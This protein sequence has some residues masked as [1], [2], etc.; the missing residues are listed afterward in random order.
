MR[1]FTVLLA[2]LA[3]G[4]GSGRPPPPRLQ[5][6]AA[7]ALTPALVAY[8]RGF[9]GAAVHSAGVGALAD[10]IRRGPRPDLVAGP[11]RALPALYSAGLV[12][13]P[14]DF[15][16]ND[17]VLVVPVRDPRVGGLTQLS[18]SGVRIALGRA[19]SPVGMSTRM[20]LDRLGAAQRSAILGNVRDRA[21]DSAVLARLVAERRTDAAFVYRTAATRWRG[22]LLAIDLSDRLAPRVRFGIAVV[23]G[24]A[25][26]RAARAF[27]AGL[28]K[29]RGRRALNAAGFVTAPF[30]PR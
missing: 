23:S 20:V 6:A 24:A 30:R 19:G 4:C 27:V 17:L 8:A 11:S 26:P 25:H 14:L 29:A 12:E 13:K 2:L 21:G 15:A 18:G 28:D 5:V 16:Q 1:R 10:R 3:A 7:R 22:R 9:P